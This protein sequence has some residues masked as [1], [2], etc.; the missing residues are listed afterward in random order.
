MA[1]YP[2][3]GSRGPTTAPHLG[4]AL[5][6]VTG[7]QAG[8]TAPLTA[9]VHAGNTLSQAS[10]NITSETVPMASLP[11]G[12]LVLGNVNSYTP[13]L[14]GE[15]HG[16]GMDGEH[17]APVLDLLNENMPNGLPRNLGMGTQGAQAVSSP[18]TAA[19][20]MPA[21]P[22]DYLCQ[23]RRAGAWVAD[24][25]DGRCF[26]LCP[27]TYGCC[28]NNACFG[29]TPIGITYCNILTVSPGNGKRAIL[30]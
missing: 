19:V 6:P 1:T 29:I 20:A 22:A 30:S 14:L 2:Q 27:T 25:A 26:A 10:T 11:P 9:D 16:V 8:V 15:H 28:P 4:D 3:L 21:S 13:P 17:P 24:P 5:S 18:D 23:G 7:L 12:S